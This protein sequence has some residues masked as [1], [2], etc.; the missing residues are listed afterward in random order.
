[1]SY[2]SKVIAISLG[3]YT[4]FAAT[5]FLGGNVGSGTASVGDYA[6]NL[7]LI[8]LCLGGGLLLIGFVVLVAYSLNTGQR[9]RETAAAGKVYRPAVYYGLPFVLAGL[10]VLVIGTS[11]CFGGVA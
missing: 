5:I 9:A 6:V 11:I 1:M 3:I 4:L 10:L 2:R 7:F 8:G